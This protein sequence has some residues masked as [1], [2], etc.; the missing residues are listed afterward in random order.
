MPDTDIR[1]LDQ[2]TIERIAAGE[3]VE[4]PASV[5]KELV[6]NSLDADADRV[7]VAVEEGGID[8]ITISDDG[9]GMTEVDVRAAVQEHTTSKIGDIDDLEGGVSTLGF[10]G[11]ALHT[12]GAVSR[13]TIRTKPRDDPDAEGTELQYEGGEVESVR[14]AGCPVG[15][16]IEVSDLFYNTP[17]R[18]KYLKTRATEFSHVNRVVTRYALANPNVAVTL[19]HDGREVFATTG[20]GNRRSTVM[21]VY[22]KEVAK[23]MHPVDLDAADD[24]RETPLDAVSGLV[25]HPE[26]TR[27][28]REYV[29]TFVN[30]R[31]VTS[32]LVRDAVLDAYGGQL[33]SDRYPFVVLF[34]EL[35]P[36]EVDVNVH[37][38]KM[39][40]R[41]GDEAGVRRQVRNAVE[42]ALLDAGL[43]RSS[44]PRGRSKAA[45]AAVRPESDTGESEEMGSGQT[46]SSQPGET[47]VERTESSSPA[48]RSGD[49][50]GRTTDTGHSESTGSVA[51]DDDASG[52][53]TSETATTEAETEADEPTDRY[54]DQ[55][56]APPDEGDGED[57]GTAASTSGAAETSPGTAET[58]TGRTRKRP[59][60]DD[61]GDFAPGGGATGEPTATVDVQEAETG[62]GSHDVSSGDMDTTMS[63][64]TG[65]EP[66]PSRKFRGDQTQT[67]LT[68]ESATDPE[69][70]ETLPSLD[71]LG[72]YRDTYLVAESDVGLVLVDQHAADERVNY[73]RLKAAFADGATAQALA[74]PVDLE[75]T[76]GEAAVF[77]DY[78][79][80]LAE[81]GFRAE[82]V[83]GKT[84][85]VSSVPAVFRKTLAPKDVRDVLAGFVAEEELGDETVEQLADHFIADLAC[86]PSITGNTSLTEGSVV[87]LL[88]ALDDCENPWA[89]P[90]GRPTVVKFDE[91]EIEDRFERDYPGHGG[92]RER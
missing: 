86:Y 67:T 49:Q 63:A 53:A 25:S 84:V 4:R 24:P 20:R 42:D 74:E 80:A 39:E 90:H 68:G 43:L 62:S 7:T 71:V 58:T 32:K 54:A 76:S 40:V 89:C 46:K 29:S 11:E 47:P 56:W 15:T 14:P 31:Y 5:V 65:H 2:A 9:V 61:L 48:E 57:D 70:Y 92:R 64:E 66:A 82:L 83:E 16:T 73:E 52:T 35:P 12:I 23:A 17:A 69:E 36:G 78:Q 41:F 19:E 30:G 13:M 28:T 45:E 51:A 18:K 72:Q 27:S 37:P 81:L 22:G 38:R 75:L 10:R 87:D 26:T 34:L 6:E 85:R 79:E 44:A 59:D 21:N 33:A 3:V 60:P 50:A 8:G 1:R 91:G 88:V 55:G 77:P